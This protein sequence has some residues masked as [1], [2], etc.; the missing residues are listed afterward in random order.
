MLMV[1]FLYLDENILGTRIFGQM[2]LTA[3]Y[4]STCV[5]GPQNYN[6]T[7]WYILGV[8]TPV[9]RVVVTPPPPSIVNYITV[10]QYYMLHYICHIT[11]YYSVNPNFP[12]TVLPL[13][14]R[15]I[16]YLVPPVES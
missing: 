2:I 3:K 10:L 7:G 16:F 4:L 15:F 12:R 6:W 9:W 13:T 5:T 1:L 14:T 8:I 11:V